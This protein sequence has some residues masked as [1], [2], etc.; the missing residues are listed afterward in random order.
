M[1]V[2]PW[3]YTHSTIYVNSLYPVLDVNALLISSR[4]LKNGTK[5]KLVNTPIKA[6]IHGEVNKDEVLDVSPIFFLSIVLL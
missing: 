1:H 6:R 2:G 5:S 4:L 3:F